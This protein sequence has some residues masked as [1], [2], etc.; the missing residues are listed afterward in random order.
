MVWKGGGSNDNCKAQIRRIVQARINFLKYFSE[1]ICLVGRVLYAHKQCYTSTS[2]HGGCTWSKVQTHK[3]VAVY[4][5][6][7]KQK[8]QNSLSLENIWMKRPAK[9]YLS[10]HMWKDTDFACSCIMLVHLSTFAP[11]CICTTVHGIAQ[12]IVRLHNYIIA[13]LHKCKIAQLQNPQLQNCTIVRLQNC[14]FAQ[15]YDC[16]IANLHKC[17]IAQLHNC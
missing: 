17:T 6:G 13:R 9:W 5:I 4:N 15:L 7:R 14:K 11:L 2:R 12:Y 10:T 16:K 3:C 1:A 8:V